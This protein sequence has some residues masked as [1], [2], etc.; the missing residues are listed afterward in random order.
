[1]EAIC[2]FTIGN[3]DVLFFSEGNITT[4]EGAMGFNGFFTVVESVRVDK[5]FLVPCNPLL[6][7]L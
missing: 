1:L 6:P 2:T 7:Q 5:Y 3:I 4:W